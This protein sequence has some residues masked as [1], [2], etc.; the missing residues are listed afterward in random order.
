MYDVNGVFQNQQVNLQ[1]TFGFGDQHKDH[2]GEF[3]SDN[4]NRWFFWQQ[5]L[6]SMKLTGTK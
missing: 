3:N 2:S 5:V 6:S 4:M 1:I